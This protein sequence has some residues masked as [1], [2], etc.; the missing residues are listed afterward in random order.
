[1]CDFTHFKTV[2]LNN[3]KFIANV[4]AVKVKNCR[5][6]GEWRQTGSDPASYSSL[7]FFAERFADDDQQVWRKILS[8]ILRVFGADN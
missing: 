3:K 6:S 2:V 5:A 7:V 1:M 8:S 4:S